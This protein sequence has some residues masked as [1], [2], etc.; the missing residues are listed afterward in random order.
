METYEVAFVVEGRVENEDAYIGDI[1]CNGLY[2]KERQDD[3]DNY[4]YL[5]DGRAYYYVEAENPVEAFYK[6]E[7][8]F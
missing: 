6:A 4:Y 2:K 3:N 7:T 8:Y 1:E 5:K